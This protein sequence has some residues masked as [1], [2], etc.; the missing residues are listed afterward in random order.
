MTPPIQE[1]CYGDPSGKRRPDQRERVALAPVRAGAVSVRRLGARSGSRR[2]G[3]GFVGRFTAPRTRLDQARLQLAQELG[4]LCQ[5]LRELA[6]ETAAPGGLLRQLPQPHRAL[7]EE[8]VSP[9]HF[10]V[11]GSSPV[12]IRQT[13]DAALRAAIVAAALKPA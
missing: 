7:L 2:R 11:G 3:S 1:L 9:A 12:L 13:L 8:C 6:R 10:F 5:R 4:V